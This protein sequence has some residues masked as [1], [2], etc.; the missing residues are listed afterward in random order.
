LEK[1]C[2]AGHIFKYKWKTYQKAQTKGVKQK[3]AKENKK[4]SP[5]TQL[6]WA[7]YHRG[8][9]P[10]LSR[11][12]LGEG[13]H[14]VG[15]PGCGCTLGL[16]IPPPPPLGPT[17]LR[18]LHAAM[19]RRFRVVSK[20]ISTKPPSLHYIRRGGAHSTHTIIWSFYLT[21]SSYIFLALVLSI[22]WS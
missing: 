21:T 3:Y 11:N 2:F 14:E 1:S 10:G 4:R 22:I 13:G 15:L 7:E 6:T 20:N 16:A 12:R 8:Q 9:G 5:P 18:R 17:L 19:L